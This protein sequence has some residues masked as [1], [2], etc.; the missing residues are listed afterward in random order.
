M[1][2]KTMETLLPTGLELS[3]MPFLLDNHG[4]GLLL[5]GTVYEH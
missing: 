3:N 2:Q 4:G 5:V 1:F